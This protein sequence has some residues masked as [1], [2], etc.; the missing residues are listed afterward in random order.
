[1]DGVAW[2]RAVETSNGTEAGLEVR[3][4]SEP[5]V[6]LLHGK[7]QAVPEDLH[8]QR[9]HWHRIVRITAGRGLDLLRPGHRGETTYWRRCAA[10]AGCHRARDSLWIVRQLKGS[11]TWHLR[12]QPEPGPPVDLRFD[13]S[14]SRGAIGAACGR[15]S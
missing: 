15:R 6:R 8:D 5:V 1:M 13:L 4:E 10:T 11:W 2:T 14:G 7:L 3:C 12:A 9:P